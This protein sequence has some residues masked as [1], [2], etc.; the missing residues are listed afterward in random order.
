M[1]VAP[2]HFTIMGAEH[3]PDATATVI[4]AASIILVLRVFVV[5][6]AVA[7]TL[8]R[9]WIGEQEASAHDQ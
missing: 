7:V 5:A 2:N 6:L 4:R 9:N 3:N 8:G 1:I